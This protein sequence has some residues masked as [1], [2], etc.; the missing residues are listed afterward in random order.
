MYELNRVHLAG[1]RAVEVVGR[2]G[3]LKLAA[4]ELGVTIGAV[5][6]QVQR[7]EEVLGQKL[8]I[9]STR[10]ME[11]TA[12]GADIQPRLTSGMSELASAVRLTRVVRDDR[13]VVS[14]APMFASR[15]L[16]WR[17]RDFYTQFP[18]I[19]IRVDS[20]LGLVDPNTSDVDVCIRVGRGNW[21]GVCS[22]KLMGQ[23]IFP[24]GSAEMVR[25]IR[26]PQD[27]GSVPIIRETEQ[28]CMWHVWLEKQ[29]LDMSILGDGPVYADAA[30]CLDAAMA[31]QGIFIAWEA[32]ACDALE[33]GR[34]S[35][36]FVERVE[37]EN[38]YW[39]VTGENSARN[40]NVA[41]FTNW[42]REELSASVRAWRGGS[43]R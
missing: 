11:L 33:A 7:T 24:V 15:W 21:P 41:H 31:G 34:L 1:L 42:L 19:R 14:V 29:G 36:P 2:L 6:Q 18:T 27:L 13:L 23:R 38:S 35:A 30:L 25:N 40:P 10:G 3:S 26:V 22:E 37:T 39:C 12:I 16:V 28:Y 32:L 20:D 9:R 5:S 17:L 4:D 43:V 8:F